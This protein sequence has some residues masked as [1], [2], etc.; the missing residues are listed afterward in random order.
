VGT[1][2]VP[3]VDTALR[4]GAETLVHRALE[5]QEASPTLAVEQRSRMDR[6]REGRR[7]AL[8]AAAARGRGRP[9]STNRF[10]RTFCESCEAADLGG[11]SAR[12]TVCPHP[13]PRV[14]TCASPT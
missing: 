5:V 13:V 10:A 4:A 8:G 12:L 1:R 6:A 7:A 3:L 9:E 2:A 11:D 14:V